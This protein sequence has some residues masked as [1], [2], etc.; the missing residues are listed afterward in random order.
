MG[1]LEEV[2]DERPKFH[3]GDVEVRRAFGPEETLLERELAETVASREAVCWGIDRDVAAF[4]YE[5]LR[6]GD[7]TL[8]T[9]AGLSTLVFAIRG[10]RHVAV[11]P[12]RNEFEA[13]AEYARHKGIDMN[14]VTFVD[15]ASETYLPGLQTV[16][17]DLVLI[18]GKHAFPW[19]VIDWF[20]TAEQLKLRGLLVL[21]DVQLF[22]VRM[23]R[24]Y[25]VED[26]RWVLLRSFGYR[27]CV[28]QKVGAPVHDVAWHMQP[29]IWKRSGTKGRL[30]KLRAFLRKV[31]LPVAGRHRSG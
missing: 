31:L 23:L 8:E 17:L 6:P 27:T 20:Y 26:P 7:R 10:T 19:P 1:L 21:D 14:N 29:Y 15:K 4:I 30:R 2:L 3:R 18:D 11:T 9:G 28:L 25:L 12:N 13:I 16:E 24:D 5:A 22:S